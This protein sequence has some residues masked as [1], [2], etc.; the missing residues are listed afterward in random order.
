LSPYVV[1]GLGWFKFNPQLYDNGRYID[2]RPLRTEGQGM[3]EYKDRPIYHLSQANVPFGFGIKYELSQMFTIRGEVV[4]RFLFT[5]YLDDVSKTYID[6]SLFDKYLT[7]MQA[8]QANAVYS[9]KRETPPVPGQPRGNEDSNDSYV[10][11]SLK[12]GVTLGRERR[13]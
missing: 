7:P 13:W 2:L 11:F 1:A 5:D 6:P 10:T 12:L 3:A 8:S 4:H 9:R